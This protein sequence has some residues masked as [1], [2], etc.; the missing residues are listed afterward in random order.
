MPNSEL[1]DAL[2]IE[3][4]HVRQA[5]QEAAQDISRILTPKLQQAISQGSSSTSLS[6]FFIDSVD[7]EV[8]YNPSAGNATMIFANA[9]LSVIANKQTLTDE[10]KEIIRKLCLSVEDRPLP[11][12]YWADFV[13]SHLDDPQTIRYVLTGCSHNKSLLTKRLHDLVHRYAKDILRKERSRI[14]VFGYSQTIADA[15]K[16]LTLSGENTFSI[17]TPQQFLPN[18][19]KSDGE[20][21]LSRLRKEKVAVPAEI[22][23]DEDALAL[24]SAGKCDLLMMGCKVIGS[25]GEGNLE[26]VNSAG[27]ME[28]ATAASKAGI[29]TGVLGGGYKVWPVQLYKKHRDSIMQQA[30]GVAPQNSVIPGELINWLLTEHALYTPTEFREIYKRWFDFSG[31]PLGSVVVPT[32]VE[33]ESFKSW[34]QRLGRV[35]ADLQ[36]T[37]AFLDQPIGSIQKVA[38]RCCELL[39]YL[40]PGDHFR[41]VTGQA[42]RRFYNIVEPALRAARKTKN[43]SITVVLGPILHI[44]EDDDSPILRLARDEIATLYISSYR[45][46]YHYRIFGENLVQTEDYHCPEQPDRIIT[47]FDDDY[48]VARYIADFNNL[49]GTMCTPFNT[50]RNNLIGI[51]DRDFKKLGWSIDHDFMDFGEIRTDLT[52]KLGNDA[53]HV[54]EKNGIY[55]FA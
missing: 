14:M 15:L 27:A 38:E 36:N 11:T 54:I 48:S 32:S 13:Q 1:M 28:F 21:L 39:E 4:A 23:K 20:Q 26:I 10:A 31:L 6:T 51:R 9:V 37:K 52:S 45:Q 49:V 2:N 29:P 3:P 55:M 25:T 33:K 40:N 5:Q 47:E 34:E 44:E 35:V 46:R 12:L 43:I 19:K 18:R 41:I 16:G 50:Q 17:F 30:T 24:L 7:H 8:S 53:P 42:N 22:V